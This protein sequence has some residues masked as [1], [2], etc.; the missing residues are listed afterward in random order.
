MH[1]AL[2]THHYEPEVG[3]PQ[4]RWTA[5]V[6]RFIAAG[7]RVTVLAPAPH[8]PGGRRVLSNEDL[9]PGATAAGHHGEI[10]LRLRFREH[11]PGLVSRTIDQSVTAVHAVARGLRELRRRKD[12]PDVVVVTVPGIPSIGAGVVLHHLL[13]VPLVIEMRDAWPDLIEPSGMLGPTGRRRGWRRPVAA[14]TGKLITGAQRDANA[15]VTTTES[16]ARILADRR[17][18]RLEVVRNGAYLEEVPFLG[19]AQHDGPLRIL[20]LGTVGRS[21]GLVTA[22][23]AAAALHGRGVPVE[24]RI[25]GQGVDLE[26]VRAL[27]E[28]LGAPVEVLSA[29]PR[30]EVFDHYRWAHTLLVALRGWKPLEWTVPSKLY[31]LM[32]S[33]RHVTGVLAGEA[34]SIVRSTGAGDVVAP[35]DVEGLTDLWAA[36]AADRSRLAVGTGGR[37]WALDNANYERLT[38]HYLTLL[39]DLVP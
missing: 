18:K 14:A 10:V 32:V 17:M 8:Y 29:V 38:A 21:Q 30:S 3:A 35:E 13:R 39:A 28:K 4:R 7:H 37:E 22:V 23:R 34:A 5:L 16:F 11:G 26:R 6:R 25:V 2:I 31:E 36:L 27:A 15:I 12:R 19:P 1:I 20:Y 33:G 24:L 9:S